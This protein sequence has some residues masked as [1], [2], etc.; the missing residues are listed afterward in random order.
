MRIKRTQSI[1]ETEVLR[2]QHPKGD[3]LVMIAR[4]QIRVRFRKNES[5]QGQN[6]T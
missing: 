5:R 1:R 6:T 2:P 3:K 4:S